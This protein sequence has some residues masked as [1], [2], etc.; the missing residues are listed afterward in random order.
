M[1]FDVNVTIRRPP[2]AVFAMLI[3]VQDY[4]KQERAARVP[5]MEK[6]T[7]GPT[8][9]GTRWR[10][11]IRLAPRVTFTIWS[12][13]VAIEQDRLLDE[14]FRSWWMHGRLEYTMT[15]SDGGTVLRQRER[16]E[17]RGPFRLADGFIAR[18]LGPNIEARLDGIRRLLEEGQGQPG[19]VAVAG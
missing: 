15:A 12:E 2:S 11:V 10:E 18:Q 8:R 9:V 6:V 7:P 4:G 13:V 17:G 14:R 1:Y 3:D 5:V 19:P 16:L